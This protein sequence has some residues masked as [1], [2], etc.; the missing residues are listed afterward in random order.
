M[1]NSAGA[2]W[3]MVRILNN[4][5]W[6]GSGAK[7]KKSQMPWEQW[8]DKEFFF[9]WSQVSGTSTASLALKGVKFHAR[10]FPKA[11]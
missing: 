5:T 2:E 4:K 10:D 9:C 7:K 6:K 1:P 3:V 8:F 11:L